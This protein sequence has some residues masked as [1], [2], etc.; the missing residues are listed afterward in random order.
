MSADPSSFSLIT[1]ELKEGG[2][3]V[4]SMKNGKANAL[5]IE[6]LGELKRAMDYAAQSDDVKGILLRS[7]NERIYCAGLDLVQITQFLSADDYVDQFRN[8]IFN[9]MTPSC[10]TMLRCPKPVATAV[11]GHCLAGGLVLALCSDY[12][13]FG[14]NDKAKV[15][16]T[17]LAIPVPFPPL[18]VHVVRNRVDSYTA[19][20]MIFDAIVRTPSEMFDLG[21]GDAIS[22]DAEANALEWLSK[23]ITN[24]VVPFG[25]TKKLWWD[26]VLQQAPSDKEQREWAIAA[27]NAIRPKSSL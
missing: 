20:Q 19:R 7:S 4:I 26:P 27:A 24:G 16:L 23:K 11:N 9:C 2:I 1:V 25:I 18:P 10:E 21:V 5:S 3:F 13:C 14:R 22:D 8:F 15:G 12:L 6:H 17:E